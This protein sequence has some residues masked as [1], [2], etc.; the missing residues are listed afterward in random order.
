MLRGE[1]VTFQGEGAFYG[2]FLVD[3]G[4]LEVAGVGFVFLEFSVRF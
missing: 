1:I 4:I 2:M 3:G